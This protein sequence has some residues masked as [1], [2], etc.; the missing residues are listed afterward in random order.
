MA[1]ASISLT[2]TPRETHGRARSYALLAIGVVAAALPLAGLLSLLM[3]SELAEWQGGL[4]V[5]GKDAPIDAYI[6]L[7][8]P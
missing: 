6:L 5:K 8:L 1:S 2:S 4:R 7:A 3:R